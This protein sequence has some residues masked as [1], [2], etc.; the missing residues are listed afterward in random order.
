MRLI[1]RYDRYERVSATAENLRNLHLRAHPGVQSS[2]VE[3]VPSS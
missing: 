2:G 3:Q 1:Q